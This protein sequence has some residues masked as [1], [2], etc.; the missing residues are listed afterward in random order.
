MAVIIPLLMAAEGVAATTILMTSVAFSVTGI[1]DKI[2]KV[3]E[4]V[5]GKDLVMVGNLAGMI[6]GTFGGGFNP[7]DGIS[8]A[9][10]LAAENLSFGLT[11][12]GLPIMADAA[13]TV[14]SVVPSVADNLS[15]GLT[16]EGMP[17]M[18]D[19]VATANTA[20][21]GLADGMQGTKLMG[22]TDL[23]KVDYSPSTKPSTLAAMDTVAA[24]VPAPEPAA[25]AG[26]AA[27][28]TSQY[29]LASAP[30]ATGNQLANYASLPGVNAT[31]ATGFLAKLQAGASK[32]IDSPYMMA[33]LAQG[34][35]SGYSA[36]QTRA[37]Q[38]AQLDY[39]QRVANIGSAGW[40]QTQ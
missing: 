26:A 18:A 8:S 30:K 24:P 16:A 12:E 38:Q 7:A 14:E 19:S 29:S 22:T 25:T 9:N 17:I 39:Q 31:D 20:T 36:A 13:T 40:V 37:I 21:A 6:Y 2:N 3:A 35:A 1:N 27:P 11:A 4:G 34:V 5:F 23:P 32:V 33:G 10:Q 28:V 15:F